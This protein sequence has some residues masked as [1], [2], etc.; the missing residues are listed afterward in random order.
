M[1]APFF[2]VDVVDVGKDILIVAVRVFHGHFHNGRIFNAF[3]IDWFGVDLVFILVHVADEFDD[4]AF[5]ME[6][7][8]PAGPLVLQGDA[9]AF[10]QEG[11]LAQ[12]QTQRV[13]VVDRFRED[14]VVGLEMDHRPRAF[15]RALF[16]KGTHGLAAGEFDAVGFAVA[17]DFDI[18]LFRQGIDAGNADAVQAARDLIPS[19]AEFAAGVEDRH[20]HFNGRFTR[21]VHIHGNAAAIIPDGDAVVL[22]DYDVD[23]R[24]EP[25]QGFVDTV[26]D[27]FGHQMMQAP[28]GYAADVHARPL[29]Y[30]FQALQDLDLAGAVLSFDRRRLDDFLVDRSLFFLFHGANPRRIPRFSLHQEFLRVFYIVTHLFLPQ[31]QSYSG[32]PVSA[33]SLRKWRTNRFFHRSAR[34]RRPRSRRCSRPGRKAVRRGAAG[35]GGTQ[36]RRRKRHR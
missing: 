21:L 22:F 25:C 18:H 12:A 19:V 14:R 13:I 4:A 17:M 30:G 6:F 20:D 10:V 31:N 11:Q 29:A 3:H 9:D 28:G 33:G 32:L 2:R 8:F 1:R 34:T 36:C 23:I 24:T 26:I 7:L 27:Y 16:I 5:E 15:G 35:P